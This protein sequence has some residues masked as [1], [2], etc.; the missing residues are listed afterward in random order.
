MDVGKN[1]SEILPWL[2]VI[3]NNGAAYIL[4]YRSI[5]FGYMDLWRLENGSNGQHGTCLINVA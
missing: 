4:S 1:L 2:R 3:E 5:T